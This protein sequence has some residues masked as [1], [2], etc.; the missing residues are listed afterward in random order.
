M[1]V[2]IEKMVCPA[3]AGLAT[4]LPWLWKVA[5][6]ALGEPYLALNSTWPPPPCAPW[7]AP[8]FT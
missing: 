5:V 2:L 8:K 6:P 4:S 3:L 7:Q 1:G